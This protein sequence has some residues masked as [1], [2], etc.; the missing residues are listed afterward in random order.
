MH[1]NLEQ[2]RRSWLRFETAFPVMV[3]SKEF[4]TGRCIARNLSEG[5]MFLET[6]D[7]LPLGTKLRVWF[8]TPE[9]SVEICARGMVRNRSFITYGSKEGPKKISGMGIKF[10]AFYGESEQLLK[11]SVQSFQ[12]VH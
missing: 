3:E 1:E 10:I 8:S 4:G 2:E 7:P 11:H 12:A 6:H 9:N 5:G